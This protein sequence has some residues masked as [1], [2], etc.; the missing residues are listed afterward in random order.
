MLEK[1][2]LAK[3]DMIEEKD[4]NI[5]TLVHQ[6]GGLEKAKYVLSFRTNQIRKELEPKEELADRLKQELQKVDEEYTELKKKNFE[7]SQKL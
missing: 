5:T 1:E 2:V 6:V 7:V 4:R 3:K